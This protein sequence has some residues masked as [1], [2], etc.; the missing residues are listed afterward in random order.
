M[1][2][3]PPFLAYSVG[4]WLVEDNYGSI[5]DGEKLIVLSEFESVAYDWGVKVVHKGRIRIIPGIR[6]GGNFKFISSVNKL[7]RLFYD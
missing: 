6:I 2:N 5:R 3:K 1:N 4:S 7:V